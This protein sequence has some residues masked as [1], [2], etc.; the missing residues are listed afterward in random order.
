MGQQRIPRRMALHERHTQARACV[1]RSKFLQVPVWV[2]CF[3]AM[4]CAPPSPGCH[5]PV[6]ESSRPVGPQRAV[7][8][9]IPPLAG[10]FGAVAAEATAGAS[11]TLR[12]GTR[13]PFGD[14]IL[15]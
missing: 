9:E 5:P 2:P 14:R 8:D 4:A 1:L 13:R 15:R 10:T 6:A 11:V 3:S 12:T 7:G